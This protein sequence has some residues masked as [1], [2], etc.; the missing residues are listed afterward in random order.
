MDVNSLRDK[1]WANDYDGV[2][3]TLKANR[4]I[5][6]VQPTWNAD[7]PPVVNPGGNFIDFS[8]TLESPSKVHFSL[9]HYAVVNLVNS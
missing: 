4:H 2:F 3:Q 8:C 6:E 9:L 5:A 1:I 7:L